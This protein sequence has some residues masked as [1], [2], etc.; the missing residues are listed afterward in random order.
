MKLQ[1]RKF[2]HAAAGAATLSAVSGTAWAQPYPTRPVRMIV[3]FPA[4]GTA[5]ILARL[6]SQSL[7][8]QLGQ[9]FVVENRAGAGSNIAAESV[10]K[11]NPDGY[12]LFFFTSANTANATLYDKLNFNLAR[13]FA[14]VASVATSPLV[15]EINPSVPTSTVAEFIAYA[16]AN[17]GKLSMA[18]GG[19]GTTPHLAGELFKMMT[20][21]SMQHVPYRGASAAL[22]DLIS[23]RVQVMFDIVPT[24][25]ETIRA[26]RL[27]A[28]AVS[29]LTRSEALPL[30]PTMAEFVPGYEA[31]SLYGIVAPVNTPADIV[32]KL[33]KEINLALADPKI[34][35][36]FNDLS[37][38]PSPGSPA[39]CG[40]VIAEDTEKWAKVI[41]SANIKVE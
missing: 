38:A 35:A 41:K 37:S 12:T 39:D 4:G 18:S 8:E 11:A 34:R 14:P 25:I 23:G 9:A 28:I 30:V 27:R 5:D 6:I 15:L 40:K 19:I 29:T 20:G 31:S 36:R 22:P 26:G 21:V 3:G 7:A 33:N 24:S 2:L 16:K 1:R 17:P 32:N 10:A 13:D